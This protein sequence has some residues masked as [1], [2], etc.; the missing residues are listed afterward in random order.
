MSMIITMEWLKN[1]IYS[2]CYEFLITTSWLVVGC[3]KKPT[4][5]QVNDER[6]IIKHKDEIT[7]IKESVR[8]HTIK[9]VFDDVCTKILQAKNRSLGSIIKEKFFGEKEKHELT[10]GT[11]NHVYWR[12]RNIVE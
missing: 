10:A 1:S 8:I 9:K 2:T 11:G 4:E 5:D 7:K 3:R 6:W 12:V